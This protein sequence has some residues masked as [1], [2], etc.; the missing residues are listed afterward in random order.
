MHENNLGEGDI[1]LGWKEKDAYIFLF[2]EDNVEVTEY[3]VNGNFWEFDSKKYLDTLM[4]NK[5]SK[6][7]SSLAIYTYNYAIDNEENIFAEDTDGNPVE[8]HYEHAYDYTGIDKKY[9]YF[10]DPQ[11]PEKELRIPHKRV[12]EIFDGACIVKFK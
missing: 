7:I 2:G 1:D 9:L 12:G 4:K 11:A 10:T 3:T 8:L 5:D 6:I